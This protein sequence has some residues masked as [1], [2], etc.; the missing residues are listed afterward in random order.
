MIVCHC[1]FRHNFYLYS[2]AVVVNSLFDNFFHCKGVVVMICK[3]NFHS[4]L[5]KV[6]KVGSFLK[7]PDQSFYKTRLSSSFGFCFSFLSS[8]IIVSNFD[9]TTCQQCTKTTF[10]F[11]NS[12]S[13]VS[14]SHASNTIT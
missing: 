2:F 12:F 6:K 7:T 10:C 11:V 3:C 9:A 5:A 4:R 8:T 1:R 14:N 13:N